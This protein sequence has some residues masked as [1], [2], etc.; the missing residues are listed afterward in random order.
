MVVGY[1]GYLEMEAA[2]E[3]QKIKKRPSTMFPVT[4]TLYQKA[5]DAKGNLLAKH[6]GI[7]LTACRLTKQ[8][9]MDADV[10]DPISEPC[11][12]IL[13]SPY[14]WVKIDK[15]LQTLPYS[16]QLISR[17][18]TLPGLS[19]FFSCLLTKP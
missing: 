19:C 17:G 8:M 4:K 11:P 13:S 7:F 9:S 10:H 14:W 18:K 2:L 3:T 16:E 15:A 1:G 12:F 6:R 5:N